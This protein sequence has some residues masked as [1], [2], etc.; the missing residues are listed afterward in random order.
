MKILIF[1]TETTGL[2]KPNNVILER[3]PKIIEF[4]GAVINENFD[5]IY[6]H[7]HMIH[8]MEPLTPEITRIT[9][10]SDADVKDAP[11]FGS[12]AAGIQRTFDDADLSIAHNI[13]FDN[14]MVINEFKRIGSEFRRTKHELCTSELVKKLDGKRMSLGILHHRLVGQKFAAHRARDDVHAL[15][16]VIHKFVESGAID[17]DIYKD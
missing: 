4:Y 6:E 12:V 8:S 1:D 3:Q 11:S 15:I 9:G 17:F 2:L 14:G 10:I 7:H 5:L 16:R 13:S